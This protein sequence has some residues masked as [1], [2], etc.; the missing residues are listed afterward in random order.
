MESQAV[1]IIETEVV[2]EEVMSLNHSRLINRLNVLLSVAYEEQYD[3]LPE[4]EFELSTGRLKPDVAVLPRLNYNWR[5][6]VIRYPDPPITAIEILS[7]TQSFDYLVYK[8]HNLY[9]PAGV[10]SAW[11][12]VP[13]VRNIYLFVP[14]Q[15]DVVFTAGTLRDPVSQ[16]ELEMAAIFR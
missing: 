8:I 10:Q 14:N 11:L 4:L 5:A 1:E 16:V 6:D 9:F 7:P 13:T 12:V 15:P 3:I 2:L